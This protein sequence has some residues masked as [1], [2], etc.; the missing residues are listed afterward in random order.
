MVSCIFGTLAANQAALTVQIAGSGAV[1]RSPSSNAYSLNQSVTL[2]ATAGTGQ[3]FQGWSGDASG[4]VSSL[5][6]VMDR[7]RVITAT[8]GSTAPPQVSVQPTNLTVAAGQN[9]EFT[10]AVTGGTAL[11]Y[12]WLKEGV[13]LAG[14]TGAGLSLPAVTFADAGRY[15]VVVSYAGGSVTSAAAWLVVDGQ[16]YL[17]LGLYPG[18]SLH[19]TLGRTYRIDYTVDVAAPTNWLPLASVML[20]NSPWMW[21]DTTATNASQRFY[22]AVEE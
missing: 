6:V 14:A 10:A 2:T 16:S 1:T 19:G 8:F 18:L 13:P 5:T 3:K 17:L 9:V 4:S 11:G 12:Q 20:T 22:R 7:S 21:F 15:A